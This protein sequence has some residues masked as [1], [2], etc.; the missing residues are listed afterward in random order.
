VKSTIDIL[1]HARSTYDR[2]A[3]VDR[4]LELG[5][6]PERAARACSLYPQ[7]QSNDSLTELIGEL[8]GKTLK[9]ITKRSNGRP[10]DVEDEIVFV[11]TTG[12]T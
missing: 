3:A 5:Y 12:E 7:G 11:A 6:S 10:R 1:R 4:L 8:I 9:S 2:T